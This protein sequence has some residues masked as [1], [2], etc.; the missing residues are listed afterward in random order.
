MKTPVPG[1]PF[2]LWVEDFI[3]IY[4]PAQ[5]SITLHLA[6][7]YKILVLVFLNI[8]L[9]LVTFL[10]VPILLVLFVFLPPI[11]SLL[12]NLQILVFILITT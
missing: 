1:S 2:S 5:P 6:I 3:V 7:Q 12:F 11:Q 10:Y 4:K 9:Q 8:I